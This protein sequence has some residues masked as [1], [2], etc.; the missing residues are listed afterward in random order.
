MLV[1][2]HWQALLQ[3]QHWR[4]TDQA[5]STAIHPSLRA[6]EALAKYAECED[7]KYAEYEVYPEYVES[8]KIYRI[9]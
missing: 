6:Y 4:P 5:C 8:C 9:C 3:G 1:Q 2:R 7:A